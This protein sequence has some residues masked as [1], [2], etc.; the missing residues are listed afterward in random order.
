MCSRENEAVSLYR[1]LPHDPREFPLC[2]N[3][4][5]CSRM[6][7]C[8]FAI[9]APQSG[10]NPLVHAFE[11][12]TNGTIVAIRYR[13]GGRAGGGVVGLSK[14]RGYGEGSSGVYRA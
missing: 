5:S 9:S 11:S 4:A 7:H 14:W 2:L 6:I 8:W 13:A 10:L 1:T 12:S 3:E